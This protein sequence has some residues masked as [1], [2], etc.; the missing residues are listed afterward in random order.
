L[1]CI[2]SLPFQEAGT[3][4]TFQ[5]IGGRYARFLLLFHVLGTWAFLSAGLSIFI[6]DLSLLLAACARSS[7]SFFLFFNTGIASQI[8]WEASSLSEGLRVSQLSTF[9]S[10]RDTFTGQCASE[11]LWL[12]PPDKVAE[13]QP[14]RGLPSTF[15]HCYYVQHTIVYFIALGSWLRVVHLS[16]I[17]ESEWRYCCEC[18]TSARFLLDP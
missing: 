8:H 3:I 4:F 1:P 9:L 6:L 10:N 11:S 5:S 16:F 7:H 17:T 2:R 12:L 15:V 14:S 18:L 13:H